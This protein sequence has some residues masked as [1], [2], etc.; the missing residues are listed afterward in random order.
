MLKIFGLYFILDCDLI[1]YTRVALSKV[2]RIG[3]SIS[4]RESVSE[5]EFFYFAD[6]VRR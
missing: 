5:G 3:K 4:H 2:A 6:T 1:F